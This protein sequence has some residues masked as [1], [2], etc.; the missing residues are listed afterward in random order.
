MKILTKNEIKVR[1]ISLIDGDISRDEVAAWAAKL[2]T[3]ITN[4]D[5][6]Y[7]ERSQNKSIMYLLYILSVS[8]F[9]NK[10]MDPG[11]E[12]VEEWNYSIEDYKKMLESLEN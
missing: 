5:M 12:G 9:K 7:E 11:Y 6:V 2:S 1:L 8:N 10:E 4:G 3:P